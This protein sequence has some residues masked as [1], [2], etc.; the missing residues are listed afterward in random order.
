MVGQMRERY[1][2]PYT[3]SGIYEERPKQYSVTLQKPGSRVGDV[4]TGTAS[5][6]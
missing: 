6:R 3:D 1:V 5:W 4:F 2:N